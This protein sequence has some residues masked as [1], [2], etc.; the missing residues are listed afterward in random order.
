[1]EKN[2]TLI[3]GNGEI[4]KALGL[5]LTPFYEVFYKDI[6]NEIEDKFEVINICYGYSKNFI[7][8]TK[9]YIEKYNPELTIIHSTVPVGTTRKLGKGIVHSPI[10]G[11]HSNMAKEI[12]TYPKFIGA[13][14]GYDT[15]KTA[16]YFKN[17]GLKVFIFSSPETTELAK[18][19]CTSYY[20][21][22][23]EYMKEAVK[24]AE[25]YNVPFHEIYTVWNR[26]INK[27]LKILNKENLTRPIYE[28]IKGRI[29]GHC[30]VENSYLLNNMITKLIKEKNGNKNLAS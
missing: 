28:P 17:C 11:Q 15:F 18:I 20:G 24:E 2:K 12:A 8:I 7:K 10:N 22:C 14:N 23:L 21:W 5:I 16:K 26:E 19:L 30:V 27:G 9:N 1:M 6:D 3:I 4:G 25:K 13:L 29:G